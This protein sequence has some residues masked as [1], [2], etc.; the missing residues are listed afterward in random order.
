ME[1]KPGETHASLTLQTSLGLPNTK[2]KPPPKRAGYQVL[3]VT[4]IWLGFLSDSP[5]PCPWAPAPLYLLC[6]NLLLSPGL[7]L[8]LN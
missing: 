5:V 1:N 4:G 7:E 8:L 3:K 6:L 2:Q